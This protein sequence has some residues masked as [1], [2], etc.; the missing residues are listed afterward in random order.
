[1]EA[2]R[3][4]SKSGTMSA[5]SWARWAFHAASRTKPGPWMQTRRGISLGTVGHLLDSAQADLGQHGVRVAGFLGPVVATLAVVVHPDAALL[6][7]DAN[8]QVV[9]GGRRVMGAGRHWASASR[10]QKGAWP[11]E[12][13]QV[14]QSNSPR[15]M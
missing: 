15:S 13:P 2:R 5:A 1:M 9:D 6:P 4:R 3:T 10:P 8:A 11:T 14:A 12:K 7:A